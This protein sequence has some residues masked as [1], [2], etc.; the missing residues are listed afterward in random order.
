M[1]LIQRLDKAIKFYE[2]LEREDI[3][4]TDMRLLIKAIK[5]ELVVLRI[6]YFKENPRR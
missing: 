3:P 4:N 6:F 2:G 1:N 5:S